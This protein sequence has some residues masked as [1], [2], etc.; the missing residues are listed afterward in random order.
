VTNSFTYGWMNPA[1]AFALSTLGCLL[2]IL[3]SV[4]V[5]ARPGRGRGRLL[6]YATIALGGVG[7]FQAQL[8]AVLG[9]GISGTTLRYQPLT[10]LAGFGVATVAVGAGISLVSFGHPGSLRLAIT[11]ALIGTSVAGTDYVA[12]HGIRGAGDLY[13]EPNRLIGSAALGMLTGCAIVWFI[14]S[15]QGLRSAFLAATLAGAS[16]CATHYTAMSAVATQPGPLAAVDGSQPVTGYAPV[17]LLIPAVL[18]GAAVTAMLWF[19]SVGTS[20]VYD[21]RAIFQDPDN[22]VEIEPWMIA[23]VIRRVSSDYRE[24]ASVM[25]SSNAARGGVPDAIAQGNGGDVIA[26]DGGRGPATGPLG[27]IPITPVYLA[28]PNRYPPGFEPTRRANIRP[29]QDL[30]RDKP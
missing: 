15:V 29:T 9:F 30:S 11:S 16:I 27:P 14:V 26:R 28:R 12:I 24:L 4:K 8:L 2:A 3:L 25:A 20:T 10:L 5:R 18:L 17:V 21:L 1:L 7:V 22:S 19:F 13:Y 6:V 23:E